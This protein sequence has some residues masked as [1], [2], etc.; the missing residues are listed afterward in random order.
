M[1]AR[2][3]PQQVFRTRQHADFL[4]DLGIKRGHRFE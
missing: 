3:S 1:H 2:D 4:A